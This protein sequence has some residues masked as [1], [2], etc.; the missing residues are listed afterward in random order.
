MSWAKH[1]YDDLPGTYVF[2]GRSAHKAYGLNK[3][4]FS[5][6]REE[7]RRAF[8]DDPQGYADRFD[9]TAEQRE[10]LLKSE[11]LTLLRLGANIYYVAKLAVPRGMTMQ[12]TGAAFQHITREE[13]QANLDAKADGL[14]EKLG[15]AGGFW[16][17]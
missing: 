7:N 12:D 2:D 16:R 14:E 3:L 15:K 10:A 13:F 6:N 4:L 5:F 17:G 1:D 11:F 8:E 9:L